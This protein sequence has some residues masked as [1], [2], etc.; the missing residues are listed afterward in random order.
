MSAAHR[1]TFAT[2]LAIAWLG[3]L[4]IALDAD[5]VPPVT[6]QIRE[7]ESG[8]FVAEWRVPRQL[9]PRAIPSP[10]LPETC[11]PTGERTFTERPGAWFVRQTYLCPRGL[12]EQQI[13]VDFPVLNATVS[14]ILRIE[15]LSGDR[16]AH[17]FSPGE[18]TWRVPA[19][20][21]ADS[22]VLYERARD[23]VVSGAEHFALHGVHW[24]L[25]AVLLVLGA[26]GLP[27]L[28]A[29][30]A[31]AQFVGTV[32]TTGTGFQIHPALAEVGLAAAVVLLAREALRSSDERR[33]L[34]L[35]A[36]CGG[37]VHGLGL[38]GM[39]SAPAGRD[40]AG[41]WFLVVAILGMDAVLL[42]AGAGGSL[43]ARATRRPSTR[44]SRMVVAG[45][46]VAS[47]ALVIGL[48]ATD[49]RAQADVSSPTLQLPD[50][51]IPEGGAAA[52]ASRRVA[53]QFPDATVQSFLT[54]AAFEVRHEVLVRLHK[55]AGD[56][57]IPKTG[58]LA[59]EDQDEVKGDLRELLMAHHS[60]R[61][62]EASAEPELVRVD[63]LTLDDRGVLPRPDPVVEEI[64]SAWV[65]LSAAY[66]TPKTPGSLSLTWDMGEGKLPATITDPETTR[67]MELTGSRPTLEW[68]NE[69]AEDPTPV[70]Q[71]I[72]VEPSVLWVPMFSILLGVLAIVLGFGMAR[73]G[74]VTMMG[75]LTRVALAAA[76]VLAPVGAIA[77]P[78]PGALER[79][80]DERAA[81]QIL[82]RL[83]PNV[84]R[85]FEFPTESAVY[86]R[87]AS[88]V[89]GDMLGTVYLEHRRA[90]ELEERGGA[91]A[92]V[93]AVEVLSVDS[94]EPGVAEGFVTEASWVVGG[95]VTHFGH[96]HFRQNRYDA[97]VEIA[98]VDGTWKIK[99]IEIFDERRLR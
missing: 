26:A 49:V 77:V 20:A 96:R 72:A 16:F 2:L 1:K 24:M 25:L 58:V 52:P 68:R 73:R 45:A 42:L 93:E 91:R 65:G 53:A 59:V 82:S 7:V 76:C 5:G 83:L 30:F 13:G 36:A 63:F 97:R 92:R 19:L 40:E 90:V 32:V 8:R 43:V 70:V 11:T 54:V 60:I 14:T 75:P 3:P 34:P 41:F 4:A 81:Q 51:P 12:A 80:P 55:L 98:P 85:A 88:S 33:Q 31:G 84:Y 56:L 17:S 23:A 27:R 95:T 48:P 99:G 79:T 6:L 44:V 47:V 38:T 35:L 62:D 18:R 89:A 46:A 94:V 69:L 78:L 9:P 39:V 67:S 86:D 15:L 10:V 64:E 21:G 50:L 61:I 37:L 57:E 29:A 87:L 22:R 71:A 28:A 74:N 66:L